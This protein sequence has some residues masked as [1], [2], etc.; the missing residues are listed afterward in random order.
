MCFFHKNRFARI[1]CLG[2]EKS[3]MT[4]AEAQSA[5]FP[6]FLQGWR[7]HGDFYA[8]SVNKNPRNILVNTSCRDAGSTDHGYASVVRRE[9]NTVPTKNH[10]RGHCVSRVVC[11]YAKVHKSRIRRFLDFAVYRMIS[12]SSGF[13]VL[14]AFFKRA[15]SPRRKNT[16]VL[17]SVPIGGRTK[18]KRTSG[19]PSLGTPSWDFAFDAS[20]R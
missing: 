14:C 10:A 17:V 7:E 20:N 16:A 5:P 11:K 3:T 15:E 8:S 13:T 19:P 2:E 1:L 6:F 18:A 4:T 9:N 12:I